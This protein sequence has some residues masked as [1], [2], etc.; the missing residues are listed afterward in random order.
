[1]T[2]PTVK[3][4][5]NQR[6]SR[7]AKL[8]QILVFCPLKGI[9]FAGD[10]TLVLVWSD[11]IADP[12]ERVDQ[13]L[14]KSAIHFRTKPMYQDVH[15]VGLRIETEIPNV[16][17][18]HCFGHGTTGIA[19]QEFEQSKFTGLELNFLSGAN[20]FPGEEIYF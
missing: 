6:L 1:M 15:N 5:A 16:F 10:R 18:N 8:C 7:T 19:Q 4:A 17:Q 12:S 20:D 11:D 14:R 2:A 9:S 13:L 3:V